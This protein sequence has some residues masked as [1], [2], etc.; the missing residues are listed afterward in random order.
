[1]FGVRP[2]GASATSDVAGGEASKPEDK[3]ETLSA[4]RRTGSTWVDSSAE[5]NMSEFASE[6]ELSHAAAT[7]AGKPTTTTPTAAAAAAKP[8]AAAAVQPAAVPAAAARV[9]HATTAHTKPRRT[10][11]AAA[12]PE[13]PIAAV[14]HAEPVTAVDAA[15]AAWLRGSGHEVEVDLPMTLLLKSNGVEELVRA[16]PEYSTLPSDSDSSPPSPTPSAPGSAAL[17]EPV[18][19]LVKR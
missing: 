4:G 19:P 12:K 7:A 13:K 1:M 14:S 16:L 6:S 5:C 8:T 15:A 2:G 17:I 18:R 9:Q 11:A 3:N 10:T